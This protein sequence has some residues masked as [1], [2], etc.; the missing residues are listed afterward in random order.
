MTKETPEAYLK[1]SLEQREQAASIYKLR[2]SD[3]CVKLTTENSWK[4]PEKPTVESTRV[5]CARSR[6]GLAPT[7]RSVKLSSRSAA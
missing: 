4:K 3:G 5:S 2:C 6:S 7:R 1:L